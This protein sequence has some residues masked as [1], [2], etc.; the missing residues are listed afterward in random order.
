MEKLGWV[1]N[2][3][4]AFA[5]VIL[6][7]SFFAEPLFARAAKE[8]KKDLD[9]RK[10][11]AAT[12]GVDD[13]SMLAKLVSTDLKMDE[14]RRHLEVLT[15]EKPVYVRHKLEDRYTESNKEW[16]RLY[17]TN[18]LNSLGHKVFYEHFASGLNFGIEIKG[19]E[20]PKEVFEVTAHYDTVNDRV[21]GADDNGSG[22]GALLEFARIFTLHPPKKSLRITFMDLEE[23]GFVG[24]RFHAENLANEFFPNDKPHQDRA[25]KFL[26]AL[27]LDTI[28]WNPGN[29][30]KKQMVVLEIGEGGD[31]AHSR[32]GLNDKEKADRDEAYALTLS[33]A[34]AACFQFLRFADTKGIRDGL[35]LRV[36]TARAKSGTADHGSY[37]EMSLPAML[38]AAPY[39]GNYINP[40]Y[41][42]R[43]DKIENMKWVYYEKVMEFAV[44]TVSTIVQAEPVVAMSAAKSAQLRALAGLDNKQVTREEDHVAKLE[45][46]SAPPPVYE[47]TSSSGFYSGTTSPRFLAERQMYEKLPHNFVVVVEGKKDPKANLFTYRGGMFYFS[48]P[49]DTQAII[50]HAVNRGIPVWRKGDYD[51]AINSDSDGIDKWIF[52]KLAASSHE[53]SLPSIPKPF[54]AIA[55]KEL[56]KPEPTS[57]KEGKGKVDP[58]DDETDGTASDG[59][60]KGGWF[61]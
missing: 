41:H 22:L 54:V 19:T 23:Q 6:I 8:P 45:S 37:W 30:T 34:E 52:D 15:G 53:E 1:K 2:R 51:I 56:P 49:K 26:G 35:E 25:K 20:S 18:F 32:H 10:W 55:K 21:P 38:L 11:L 17:I 42:T 9:C 31:F 36:D 7:L 28:A 61:F 13:E 57:K 33:C 27:V 48:N 29:G 47:P 14:I 3:G 39:E 4:W 59:K 16:S 24:S 58:N 12:Q 43:T 5:S 46:K 60:K 50:Q 44:E 40:H